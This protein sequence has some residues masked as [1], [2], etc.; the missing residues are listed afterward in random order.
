LHPVA[1]QGLNLGLRDAS[2]LARLLAG[3]VDPAVLQAFQRER[4]TDRNTTIRLTDLMARIFTDT[5]QHGLPQHL[6]GISLGL[7][8]AFPPAKKLLAEQMMFGRRA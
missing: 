8:D 4:H 2:I 1:G 5:S 7:I 6:L 3:K